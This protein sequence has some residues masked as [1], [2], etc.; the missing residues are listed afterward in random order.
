MEYKRYA[1]YV[2]N[3]MHFD[4]LYRLFLSHLKKWLSQASIRDITPAQVMIL[5]HIEDHTL[6]VTD[7]L[8]HHFYFASNPAYNLKK[9]AE[10]GYIQTASSPEDKRLLLISLTPK[11]KTLHT[12]LQRFFSYQ[13][14]QL[15]TS[16]FAVSHFQEQRIYMHHMERLLMTPPPSLALAV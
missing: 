9:M 13:I 4:K 5:F 14:A 8:S 6:K 2:E 12:E 3:V 15:E 1:L 10:N 7:I 16:G 11:G